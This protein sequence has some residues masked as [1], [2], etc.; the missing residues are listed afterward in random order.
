MKSFHNNKK[1]YFLS[2]RMKRMMLTV[3]VDISIPSYFRFG[4]IFVSVFVFELVFVNIFIPSYFRSGD[5]P[6]G[7]LAAAGNI[8]NRSK[9]HRFHRSSSLSTSS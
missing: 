1:Y 9:F 4:F 7:E 3:F 6:D 2:E 8:C 5:K